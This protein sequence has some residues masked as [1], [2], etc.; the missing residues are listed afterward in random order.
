MPSTPSP[1]TAAR[2]ERWVRTVD[3]ARRFVEEVGLCLIFNESGRGEYPALWDVVDA[4]DKRPGERGFGERTSLVWRLKNDLPM[5][6]PDEIFYGKL[7]NGRAMLCTL[8]RL[9]LLART[10]RRHPSEAS[11]DAQRLLSVIRTRPI[12]NKELRAEAGFEGRAMES[13][14]A[15]A[16]QQ[17]QIGL[18]IARVDTD[19][20][21]WLP[22]DWVYPDLVPPARPTRSGRRSSDAVATVPDAATILRPG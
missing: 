21:T 2:R 11:R 18:L 10:Q 13:R 15:R 7:P 20:D 12:T 22:F 9:K 19:P 8:E 16:L 6:Y 3:D 1:E 17:L 4:P 5:T 14:F